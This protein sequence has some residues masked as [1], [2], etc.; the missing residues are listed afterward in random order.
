MYIEDQF[1]MIYRMCS[2]R[3]NQKG[4]LGFEFRKKISL[5]KM[6]KASNQKIEC[7]KSRQSLECGLIL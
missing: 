5:I 1:R 7:E 4:A 2:E 6:T 3:V